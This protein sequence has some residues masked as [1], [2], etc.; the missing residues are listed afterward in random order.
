MDILFDKEALIK[1]VMSEARDIER[2]VSNMAAK[3]TKDTLKKAYKSIIDQYYLY[4][5]T[6][7]YRHKTGIGTGTGKNLYLSDN[8]SIYPDIAE[9]DEEQ[10]VEEIWLNINANRM[11]GYYG[12]PKSK[13]LNMVLDGIRGVPNKNPSWLINK[14][15]NKHMMM[16]QRERN[17]T[18]EIKVERDKFKGTPREVMMQVSEKITSTYYE[19]YWNHA[20]SQVVRTGKYT[21]FRGN[22]KFTF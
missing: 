13:V 20:W 7:Y 6:S 14:R 19:M 4:K 17:F 3:K 15:T 8:I 18:A 12:F 22:K 9:F 2:K 10:R 5:T 16:F 11:Q 1:S 21:F